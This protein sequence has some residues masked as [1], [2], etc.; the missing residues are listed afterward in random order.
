MP[1]DQA[2]EAKSTIQEIVAE[3]Y[4]IDGRLETLAEGL[5]T[6]EEHFEMLSELR[7]CIDTVRGDLISDAIE[8][9]HAAATSSRE[10]ARERWLA[11]K[12]CMATVMA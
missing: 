1:R 12:R 6:P 3:L 4:R 8:T 10:R 9:L 2:S 5:P 7:A 11:R